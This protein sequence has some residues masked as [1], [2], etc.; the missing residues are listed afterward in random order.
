MSLEK[1]I[2]GDNYIGELCI[3]RG[4]PLKD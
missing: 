4:R 1:E 2:K 3:G